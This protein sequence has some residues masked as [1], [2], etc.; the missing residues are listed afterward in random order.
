MFDWFRPNSHAPQPTSQATDRFRSGL[1]AQ[2]E[3]AD[4]RIFW[5]LVAQWAVILATSIAMA[6]RWE[7]AN[8][9]ALIVAIVWVG[10]FSVLPLA[11]VLRAPGSW[12][13]R[14][15]VVGSQ[16]LMSSLLW[17]VSGGQPD[18]HLHLLAWLVV[19]TLYRDVW[20]LLATVSTALAG[21]ALVVSGNILPALPTGDPTQWFTHLVWLFG[22]TALLATFVLLDRQTLA[23]QVERQQAL[24]SLQ[25]EYQERIGDATR[26]LVEE[27]DIVKCE[28]ASLTERHAS[29]E[30]ARFEAL[31]GLLTLRRA[32]STQGAAILKLASRPAESR[33]TREW[34]ADWQTLRQ[35]AQQMMRSVDLPS[36]DAAEMSSDLTKTKSGDQPFA[37]VESDR[38]ALL[39]MRNPLQKSKAVAAME[40]EGFTVDVV[41]NGPR[42]YY[43]VMLNDYSVIVVDID[44]PDD[45]GFDTLEALRLLPPDRVG[46]NNC[47]FALTTE[48][49]PDRVL[50]CTDLAV[51]GMF[52]KPLK[53]EALRQSLNGSTDVQSAQTD[54]KAS[55]SDAA[56]AS[57]QPA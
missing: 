33:L 15:S 22:E 29:C 6:S 2:C 38:R 7:H 49:S 28:L 56:S 57:F 8:L 11:M 36:T 27:R 16:G 44:L 14:W 53:A 47:L 52:V 24:E 46:Q 48:L 41:S 26:K 45:E 50:R 19:L 21:Y 37:K 51:D 18:T 40:A 13:A 31:S 43:S 39:M 17:Y 12:Q 30:S 54:S 9:D 4:A 32:F 35:Q 25:D 5:V 34:Q 55:W 20:V 10:V 23:A 42:T 3:Q 1:V